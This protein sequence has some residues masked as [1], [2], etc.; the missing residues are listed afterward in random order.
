MSGLRNVIGG[1]AVALVA[2]MAVLAAVAPVSAQP[3]P[4]AP[5]SVSELAGA[6]SPTVVNISSIRRMREG[7]RTPFSDR[8]D[9]SPLRQFF[10]QLGPN[11]SAPER[12]VTSLGSGFVIDP[13][14]I[15]AT[16]YHVIE[17]AEE[18]IVVFADGETA[19]ARV[20]GADEKTDLAIV[21]VDLGR[22]L[23]AAAFGNS[24]SAE[25]GDWVMAIGNPFGFGG[26]VSLGIV[27]AR[28]RDIHSG[29]YDSFLQTDAAINQGNSG[30]PLFDMNGEVVGINTAIIANGGR[31]LGVGFAI[32][33]NL[34]R[35][36]L[37]QLMEFG[38]TRR[39]WLGVGIQDVTEDIAA[40][41]G[42][43]DTKGAMVLSVTPDGPADGVLRE[44]DLIFAFDGREVAEMRD[45]PRIVA[46]TAIGK[47][48]EVVIFRNGEEQAVEVTVGRLERGEI[49]AADLSTDVR[50]PPA[51]KARDDSLG[52]DLAELTDELRKKYSIIQDVRGVMVIGVDPGSDA[53]QKGIRPGLVIAEVNQH[54]V[55]VPDEATAIFDTAMD[56]GREAVLFMLAD[57]A[58]NR[59]FVAVR[60]DR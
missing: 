36:V 39:G 21:K 26:S 37:E 24:D 20:V 49:R 50:V 10:D 17:G 35:P 7:V 25:I 41:L 46:E 12:E 56:S 14:G 22:A 1:R 59:R 51:Q 3:R 31:S 33:I 60:I 18:I 8:S 4:T 32:P 48:A 2:A 9:E 30:G 53:Y 45:L 47:G 29:P 6:L 58:G 40:S 55:G 16:N 52:M 43:N 57:A 28:N 5:A 13:A 44:G 27:S 19:E 11:D 34:A 15:I 42:L 54:P 38:E 23:S